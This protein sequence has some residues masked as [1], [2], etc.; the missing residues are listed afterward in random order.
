MPLFIFY[1]GPLVT[2]I[3]EF[4]DAT[5]SVGY[6]GGGTRELALMLLKA[7]GIDTGS[8]EKILP[9]YGMDA[10]HALMAGKVDVVFLTGDTAQPAIMSQLLHTRNVHIYSFTQGGAYTRR[11]PFLTEVEV[12]MGAFDLGDNLPS[13][14]VNAIA[15]RVELVARNTLHP[16]LSDL[17]IEAL[18]EVHSGAGMLQRPGEFPAPIAHDFPL[19]PDAARYYKSGKTFLY[20]VM[21]FWMA[22]LADRLIFFIVPVLVVL[23]PAIR[24]VPPIYAWRVRSRIFRWYGELMAIE[25]GAGNDLSGENRAELLERLDQIQRSVNRLRLPSNYANLF[26]MLREHIGF[27]R[28]RLGAAG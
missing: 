14:S 9:V 6:L 15:T 13:E 26:Y 22:S 12:P 23:I 25:H 20:R 10:V 24:I 18:Y 5:F 3:S 27:V 2:R 28:Q 17:I 21:P 1:R 19:S 4:K 16:A 7:N 8:P 11:F